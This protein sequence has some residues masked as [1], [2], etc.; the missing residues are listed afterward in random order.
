MIQNGT[1]NRFSA[2]SPLLQ[3][4]SLPLSEQRQNKET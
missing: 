4:T 3:G 1:V 2:L